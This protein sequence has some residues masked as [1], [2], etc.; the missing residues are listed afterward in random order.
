MNLSWLGTLSPAILQRKPIFHHINQIKRQ[1]VSLLK[2]HVIKSFWWLVLN[3]NSTRFI[4]MW[5]GIIFEL[6]WPVN[7]N[8]L[9]R[10]H[11]MK[12]T[13]KFQVFQNTLK[14][15]SFF[16]NF[17]TSRVWFLT[18]L[19]RSWSWSTSNPRFAVV[20]DPRQLMSMEYVFVHSFSWKK[21]GK[22][23]RYDDFLRF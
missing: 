2:Y 7:F 1:L 23:I 19:V 15:G 21:R 18:S 14:K 16:F 9:S 12:F 20:N 22:A 11:H 6:W 13:Q 8:L 4:L 3:D 10:F 17:K 5:S